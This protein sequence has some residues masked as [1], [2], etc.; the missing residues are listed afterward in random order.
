MNDN[1]LSWNLH[2]WLTVFLMFL[3]GWAVYCAIARVAKSRM[4]A[5]QQPATPAAQ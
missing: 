5:T 3:A 1:L 4:G 2:N